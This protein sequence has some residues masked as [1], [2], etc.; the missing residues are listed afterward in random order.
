MIDP[1]ESEE[2]EQVAQEPQP[3]DVEKEFY[4]EIGGEG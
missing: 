4:T 2:N 1:P 3:V